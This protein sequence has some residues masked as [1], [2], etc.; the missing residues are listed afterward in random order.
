MKS[1]AEMSGVKCATNQDCVNKSVTLT[2]DV[3][4][5]CLTSCVNK[6]TGGSNTTLSIILIII[7]VVI[8]VVVLL[9]LRKKPQKSMKEF[10][11]D[12]DKQ[13]QPSPGDFKS[14]EFKEEFGA[15]KEGK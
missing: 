6:T 7:V 15:G 11:D 2:S 13:Q 1:C 9:F 8:L 3:N 5:C 14:K 12:L 4:E 10:S